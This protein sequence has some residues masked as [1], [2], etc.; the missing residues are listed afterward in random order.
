MSKAIHNANLMALF[1]QRFGIIPNYENILE[2]SYRRFIQKGHIVVDIGAHTGRHTRVFAELVGQEGKVLAFEPLPFAF[3]ILSKTNLPNNVSLR[4]CAIAQASGAIP[5]I[6]AHGAPE[7]SGLRVKQYNHPTEVTPEEITVDAR[8]LDSFFSEIGPVNFIK[9]DAEGSEI[10]CIRSGSRLIGSH[11]PLLTVEYGHPSYSAYGN[12]ATSLFE[13]SV[14]MGY[15]IGDMFG[16]YCSNLSS[17][18]LVCDV[19]YWDWFLVPLERID[20]WQSKLKL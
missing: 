14:S 10:E 16:G 15:V 5:F 4:K 17:W 20:E 12:S 9:I 19:S 8:S 13:L 6:Y 2:A 11:R 7:E 18:L 3:D 1:H